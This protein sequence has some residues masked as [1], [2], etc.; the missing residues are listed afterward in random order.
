M[1]EFV[2]PSID[3]FE[4]WPLL[5]VFGVACLGVL[6]EAFAPRRTRYLAQV[7]LALAGLAGA[8]VGV[9]LIARD[10]EVY[11]GGA[12][13]GILSVGGTI[14][15]DGRAWTIGSSAL[16]AIVS[17]GSPVR[18]PP[19]VPNQNV[20]HTVSRRASPCAPGANSAA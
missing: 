1:T 17:R 18:P 4:L 12:A 7:V 20:E 10:A 9:V 14:A 5:T 11:A 3:Y 2:K 6:I 13:R 15:I 16:A 8:L 19:G